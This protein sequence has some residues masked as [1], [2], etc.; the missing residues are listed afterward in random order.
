MKSKHSSPGSA[1][2]P[3]QDKPKEDRA[4]THGNQT[5]KKHR[6]IKSNMGKAANNIQGDLQ[7]AIR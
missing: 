3:I 1:E 2:S 5:N 4:M 7:K 6:V